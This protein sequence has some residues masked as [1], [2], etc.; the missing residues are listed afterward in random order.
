[1]KYNIF[2]KIIS[3]EQNI[4]DNTQNPISEKE[5]DLYFRNIKRNMTHI[6]STTRDRIVPDSS[7][8]FFTSLTNYMPI[9]FTWIL[10]I[11]FVY[12]RENIF[13]YL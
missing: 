11:S 1:M 3:L 4:D 8:S 10:I 9:I 6:Y 12:F 5:T 13:E 2:E 7:T